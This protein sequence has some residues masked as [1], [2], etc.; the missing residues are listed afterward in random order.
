MEQMELPPTVRGPRVEPIQIPAPDVP[1]PNGVGRDWVRIQMRHTTPTSVVLAVLRGSNGPM[2]AKDVVDA[3][4][5]LLP[6]VT[7]GSIS[8]IG[9]RLSANVLSRTE[10]GWTLVE[11]TLAGII[12]GEWLWSPV[13]LLTK[14]EMASHRRDAILHVLGYFDTGLQTVQLVEQLSNCS[15]VQAPV[16]KDLVKEDVIKLEEEKKIR[17]RGNTKKWELVRE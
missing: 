8:N 12:D 2:R 3:V 1:I 10:A 7:A 4:L 17:R 11:P 5:R 14:Q 9:T 13:P 15:W 6:T 16:N